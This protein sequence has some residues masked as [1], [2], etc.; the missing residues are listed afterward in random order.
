VA[1]S[2]NSILRVVGALIERDGLVMV[3]RRPVASSSWPGAWEFPGGKVEEGED[4]GAALAR[5]LHE[6]LGVRVEV[7]ELFHEVLNHSEGDRC[8]DFRI[9]RC[10]ILDGQPSAI[11]VAEI[12]WLAA[13]Q[14]AELEFPTA[15]RPAV[16]ALI[17]EAEESLGNHDSDTGRIAP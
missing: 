4:D 12:R 7:G 15:D 9:Y 14:L 8:L 16:Q 6:E 11:G 17:S 5:E 13:P 1:P 3:T 2:P 10:E